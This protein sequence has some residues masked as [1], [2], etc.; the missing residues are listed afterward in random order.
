MGQ[1]RGLTP[2][3]CEGAPFKGLFRRFRL[4][5]RQRDD[6]VRLGRAI[7]RADDLDRLASLAAVDHGIAALVDGLEEVD[8]LVAVADVGDA[9]RVAGAG[10][11]AGLA[12]HG[13]VDLVVAGHFFL[14]V[15]EGDVVLLDAR[16]AAVAVDLGALQAARDRRWWL[17]R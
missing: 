5:E 13:G 10:L 6:L 2:R 16:R 4:V 11:E 8:E 15:P 3:V 1:Y 9:A 12:G 7:D 14:K 17:P